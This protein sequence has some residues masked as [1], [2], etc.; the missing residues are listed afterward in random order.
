MHQFSATLY[1]ISVAPT[2]AR[3]RCTWARRLYSFSS[4]YRAVLHERV[5]IY[6]SPNASRKDSVVEQVPCRVYPDRDGESLIRTTDR[7]RCKPITSTIRKHT[8]MHAIAH[9]TQHR[10][11]HGHTGTRNAAQPSIHALESIRWWQHTDTKATQVQLHARKRNASYV[12][13]SRT[14]RDAP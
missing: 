5:P 9:I 12:F 11:T 10:R 4:E 3:L 8:H 6:P 2:A 1:L 7:E 14:T 13:E